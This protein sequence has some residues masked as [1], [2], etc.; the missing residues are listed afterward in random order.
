MTMAWLEWH[1]RHPDPQADVDRLLERSRID[2]AWRRG[3][4]WRA[5][6]LK[7]AMPYFVFIG[8]PPAPGAGRTA[9]VR[10]LESFLILAQ[11]SRK[12][13]LQ[14][15][16]ELARVFAGIVGCSRGVEWNDDDARIEAGQGWPWARSSP[17]RMAGRRCWPC[18]T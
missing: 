4:P 11:D 18:S 7:A 3:R 15:P 12:A 13:R 16:S 10:L 17:A 14:Q 1:Q 2:E 8:P 5:D 9:A 6:Q